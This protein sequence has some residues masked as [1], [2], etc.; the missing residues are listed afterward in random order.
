MTSKTNRKTKPPIALDSKRNLS[1]PNKDTILMYQQFKPRTKN[2]ANFVRTVYENDITICHGVA[3]TGKTA[4]AV[5]LALEHLRDGKIDK[6]LILRPTVEASKKGVGYL[7]GTLEDKLGPYLIPLLD[8]IDE[9]IGE[10]KREYLIA[11]GK[12]CIECLEFFRGRNLKNCYL[13]LDEAQNATLKQIKMVQTRLCENSKVIILGDSDQTDLPENEAGGLVKTIRILDG[14][15][16]V[17]LAFLDNSDI[18]RLPI[19]GRVLEAYS[20][21]GC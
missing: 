7:K 14:I 8:Q 1:T 3:G 19:V 2:Q 10:S 6:I 12:I 18:Q 20:Q 15:E 9:Y 5:G 4:L 16:G 13:I 11:R 17:G 21:A